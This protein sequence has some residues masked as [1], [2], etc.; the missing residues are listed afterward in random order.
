LADYN[1]FLTPD[2]VVIYPSRGKLLLLVLGGAAFIALGLF[3]W[4]TGQIKNQVVAILSVVFFGACFVFGVIR[5]IWRKPSLIISPMGILERSSAL[6]S[7]L[8]RWDEIDSVFISTMQVTAFSSQRF[9]S[10]RLK[11]TE[12]FLARQSSARARLMR[13]NMGLVGAP[14]NISASTLP[15]KL[16]ELIE[17][18]QQKSPAGQTLSLP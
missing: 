15:V 12:E 18:M 16:E 7:Y 9:L 10:I 3:L 17:V 1:Q 11:N 5:L 8:L 4:R 2:A 14:I 6:G 13:M